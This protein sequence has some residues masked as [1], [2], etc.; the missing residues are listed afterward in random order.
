MLE[1][2]PHIVSKSNS[3]T[4]TNAPPMKANS[5]TQTNKPVKVSMNT[6]TN[7]PPINKKNTSNAVSI[8]NRLR[9]MMQNEFAKLRGNVARRFNNVNDTLMV[10]GTQGMRLEQD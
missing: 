9:R 6:Q 3:N 4:Q 7:A 10:V 1:A 2:Q 5:N 8:E